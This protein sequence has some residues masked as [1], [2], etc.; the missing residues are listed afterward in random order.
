M[1]KPGETYSATKDEFFRTVEEEFSFLVSEY[2]YTARVPEDRPFTVEYAHDRLRIRVSGINYGFAA[3]LEVFADGDYLPLWP[4]MTKL[5]EHKT[6]WTDKPQLDELRE[7]AWRLRHECVAIVTGSF[8]QVEKIRETVSE[9]ARKLEE[10]RQVDEQNRFFSIADKLFR[11]KK[12]AECVAHLLES[13]FA[14]SAV[15]LARLDYAKKQIPNS[16]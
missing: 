1:K 5:N 3:H 10:A 9:Q 12:Y 13:K 15:W 2:G 6:I 4:L 16:I 14:L 8:S 7:Y 11:E